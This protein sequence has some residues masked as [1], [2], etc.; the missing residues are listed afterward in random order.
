[1]HD[2]VDD[3]GRGD[4][5]VKGSG[6]LGGCWR[7]LGWLNSRGGALARTVVRGG[8]WREAEIREGE[9][10]VGTVGD[11]REKRGKRE[12]REKK[13]F[14]FLLVF[15]IYQINQTLILPIQSAR[16]AK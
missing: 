14:C 9:Q 3:D 5:V 13:R 16:L 7:A 11:E 8:G 15:K 2:D 6:Y 10:V 4:K 12:R 1:M